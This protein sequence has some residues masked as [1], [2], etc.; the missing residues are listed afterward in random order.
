MGGLRCWGWSHSKFNLRTGKVVNRGLR[1][2]GVVVEF[3]CTLSS[4]SVLT[5]RRQGLPLVSLS[6]RT[7][8]KVDE[9]GY[10]PFFIY[11]YF[12]YVN[13]F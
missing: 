1:S 11:L 10:F 7:K 3:G 9:R 4:S 12:S 13:F 2:V 6:P 8:G 5:R